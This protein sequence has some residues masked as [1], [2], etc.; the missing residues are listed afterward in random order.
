MQLGTDTLSKDAQS[1]DFII[2]ESLVLMKFLLRKPQVKSK[3]MR[4]FDLYYKVIKNLSGED[5]EKW[6]LKQTI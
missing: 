4:F 6:N 5:G 2:H 3:K 1:R